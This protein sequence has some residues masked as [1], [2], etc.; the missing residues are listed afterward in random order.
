MRTVLQNLIKEVK[1]AIPKPGKKLALAIKAAQDRLEEIDG[2]P[3]LNELA[4]VLDKWNP[5][6]TIRFKEDADPENKYGL[7]IETKNP[8]LLRLLARTFGCPIKEY[9][10]KD[11][12]TFEAGDQ[13][14]GNGRVNLRDLADELIRMHGEFFDE[15]YTVAELKQ[16]K[17]KPK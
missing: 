10:G 14:H 11:D 1:A 15:T 2:Q 12:T 3:Q 5:K 8:E 6:Y 13:W 9:P 16:F 17:L 4:I 7:S